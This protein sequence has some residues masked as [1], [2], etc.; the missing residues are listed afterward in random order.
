MTVSFDTER[1]AEVQQRGLDTGAHKSVDAGLCAMEAAAY[2]AR[3]PFSDHPQCVSPVIAAFMR[4]WNDALPS[5]ERA[6]LLPLIPLTLD[7]KASQSV[8]ERRSMMAIDWYI[9]VHTPAFL[10]LAG[11]TA[12][13]DT[14]AGFSELT[15]Q[16]QMDGIRIPLEAIR[17]AASAAWSA[18]RSAAWSAA[19]SAAR[20]AARSATESA[21]WSAAQSAA[22]S[23]AWWAAR[24]AAESAA[25]SAARS[26]A[27]SATE[28]AAW[29]AAESAAESAA[30]WAAQSAARS[31]AQSAA[32]S[33]LNG[34]R[35]ELQQSALN[36]VERMCALGGLGA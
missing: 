21:A 16:S 18:A 29:S 14:L 5:T 10:R 4:S 20:S 35:V 7:T 26:A 1:W 2:I 19:E 8:E 22:Q 15:A 30:W 9:R 12:Q 27:W 28:S 34:T 11:L 6:M 32:W 36:L 31:A 3:E 24:S 33:A 17:D 25:E 13:A 23:A